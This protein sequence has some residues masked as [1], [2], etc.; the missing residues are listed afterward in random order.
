MS[1]TM[2][3]L[4]IDCLGPDVRL[5]LLG[6]IWDSL[7]DEHDIS[8]EHR[9]ELDRRLADADANPLDR[10]PWADMLRELQ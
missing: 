7:S 9:E 10:Q 1:Q 6:E 4:G 8:E 3:D 5:R 2:Q